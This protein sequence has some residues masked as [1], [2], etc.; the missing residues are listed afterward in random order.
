MDRAHVEAQIARM[1]SGEVEPAELAAEDFGALLA[2]R[3]VAKSGSHNLI[4]LPPGKDFVVR[5]AMD[6]EKP[7]ECALE[8]RLA[9]AAYDAGVG[10][11]L[12]WCGRVDV[13]GQVVCV[14][15]WPACT[16]AE[17]YAETLAEGE[18]AKFGARLLAVLERASSALLL[19]DASTRN[20]LVTEAGEIVLIDFDP[21]YTKPVRDEKQRAAAR[22][23]TLVSAALVECTSRKKMF[24]LATL[25]A[26]MEC[27]AETASVVAALCARC[28]AVRDAFGSEETD[29]V[30]MRIVQAYGVYG[31][32]AR[33]RLRRVGEIVRA[34]ARCTPFE[35][36]R[37]AG[38]ARAYLR[39]LMHVSVSAAFDAPLEFE[40]ALD[41][42]LASHER[43]GHFFS[44][45]R[46]SR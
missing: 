27:A 34:A 15:R 14:S 29:A 40:L 24:S 32:N 3:K 35:C 7:E 10:L 4:L 8:M 41:T 38:H 18:H 20:A 44:R 19:L 9:L 30:L 17:D 25:A 21:F 11:P 1:L 36:L 37:V 6:E 33:S 31:A 22:G 13:E 42:F 28:D 5:V 45:K 2:Q 26:A 39:A 12:L 23:F 46:K 43:Y 16:C